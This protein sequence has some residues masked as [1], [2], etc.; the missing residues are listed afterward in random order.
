MKLL[1]PWKT[2]DDLDDL[3]MTGERERETKREGNEMF[4]SSNYHLEDSE[5]LRAL[6]V[7][8]VVVPFSSEPV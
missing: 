6:Q 8:R 2:G 5:I 1:W 3:E 4:M 7:E